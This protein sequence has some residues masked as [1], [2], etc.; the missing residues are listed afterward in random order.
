MTNYMHIWF[1][2]LVTKA[3]FSSV[4]IG[5]LHGG[6]ESYSSEKYMD[7]CTFEPKKN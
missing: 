4:C 2:R 7:K 5:I 1:C 3:A 6:R